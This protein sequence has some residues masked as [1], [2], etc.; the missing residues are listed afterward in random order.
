VVVTSPF[1]G[2]GEARLGGATVTFQPGSRTNWHNH[3]LGQLLIMTEGRGWMQA[4]GELVR[5]VGLGDLVW[6]APGVKHWHG[7][8][9][10]SALTHVAVQETAE[11]KSVTWLEP[12]GDDQYLGPQ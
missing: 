7:A 6:T 8:T 3:P 5:A 11:A 4:E 12:V 9:R 10:I 2:T 1:K